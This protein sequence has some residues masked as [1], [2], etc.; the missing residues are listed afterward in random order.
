MYKYKGYV[1]ING[2]R[3]YVYANTEP[4]LKDKLLELKYMKLKGVSLNKE[5]ITISQLADEWF[6]LYQTRNELSTQ[7][8]NKGI[9]DKYI[10][11]ELGG[12]PLKN[13]KSNHIQK[14]LNNMLKN[15]TDTVR[16]A[17]QLTKAILNY[18]VNNDYC[19]KNV[20]NSCE[21]PTF[22]SKERQILSHDERHI[23]ENS[24]NKYRDFFVFLLYTGLR[25]G[26][27]ASLKWSDI[28]FKN[29]RIHVRSSM[30]YIQNKGTLKSTKNDKERFVPIL[31]KTYEILERQK[32]GKSIY[33]FHKQD[34]TNLSETSIKRML[35]SFL[36]DTGLHFTLHQ[37]RHTFCT[38]LYYSG[39]SSK[40]ASQI[41]G[42]SLPV[43]LKI[44][45]HLDEQQE[46]NTINRLN[47]FIN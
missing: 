40:M 37:L 44:Y 11:V 22:K 28:D 8:R 19:L 30:S 10:K 41:M 1:T 42:H 45:T 34:G 25:R 21:I 27:I 4:E 13:L 18:A 31:N 17:F 35:E 3:K 47:D 9:I 29:K 36:K 23:I 16:K 5:T 6:E 39:V 24:K 14:M 32:D 20:A 33:V 15:K 26:E 2:K 43:M 38:I 7:K 46:N 12:I